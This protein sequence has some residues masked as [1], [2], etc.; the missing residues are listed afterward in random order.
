MNWSKSRWCLAL[1]KGVAVSAILAFF[2]YRSPWAIFPMLMPGYLFLRQ[3]MRGSREH[4]R[5]VLLLQFRECI[6]AM[7][8]ALKAGYGIENALLESAVDMKKLF[9]EKAFICQELEQIRRGMEVHIPL[10]ELLEDL[11]RRSGH[12]DIGRFA[13]IFRIAR[14]NGGNLSEIL[15]STGE[16]ISNNIEAHGEAM[17]ILSGR[18]MEQQI[19]RVMP[20]GILV[21]IEWTT[22]GYFQALYH[23]LPGVLM[24]TAC[25]GVYLAAVAISERMLDA[26]S[27]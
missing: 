1:G 4:S 27:P 8:A 10:E 11:G 22:P 12:G 9:G 3:E 18:R 26:G 23:N 17:T 20:L 15:Q 13:Q 2:F 7:S 24:M 5:E 25:L 19:M 6:L 21:Y 14:Q 16:Q